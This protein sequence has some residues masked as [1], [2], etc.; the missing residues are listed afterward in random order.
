MFLLRGMPLTYWLL[1]LVERGGHGDLRDSGRLSVIHY[2]H[3]RTELYYARVS[4]A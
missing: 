3:K 4:L 2:V 1:A